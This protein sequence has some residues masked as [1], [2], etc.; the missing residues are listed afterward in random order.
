ME[1]GIDV[2]SLSL[3]TKHTASY[4]HLT[5]Y[6]GLSRSGSDAIVTSGPIATTR[7]KMSCANI[8]T[9]GSDHIRSLWSATCSCVHCC[10]ELFQALGTVFL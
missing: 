9:L 3:G 8:V 4:V 2:T 5:W 7:A 1:N 6:S 10:V